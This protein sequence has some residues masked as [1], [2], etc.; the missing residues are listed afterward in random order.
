MIH[1]IKYNSQ[2]NN[3]DFKGKFKA[4]W[5]CFSTSAWMFMSFY[6]DNIDGADD[7]GLAEYLDD[8]EDSIGKPGIGEAVK[9]RIKWIKGNSSY[10]WAVQQ[11][12]IDAWLKRNGVNGVT[13]FKDKTVAYYDLKA[14]LQYG[15]VILQTDKMGGL[16]GGHIILAVGCQSGAIVCHDP[17]GNALT[18]YRDINGANVVY[19]D[20]FLIKYTGDMV[21]CIYLQK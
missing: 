19:D 21:R 2:R 15:P 1:K 13:L 10:W 9:Q 6:T 7:S 11:A 12:G 5:Q 14:I 8:V 20:G 3:N 17:F 18:R 4:W 16:K